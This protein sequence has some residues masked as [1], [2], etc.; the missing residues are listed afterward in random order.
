MGVVEPTGTVPGYELNSAN[1]ARATLNTHD[2]F[3][4]ERQSPLRTLEKYLPYTFLFSAG[5]R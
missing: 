4:E 1:Q 5:F 3:V 2:D